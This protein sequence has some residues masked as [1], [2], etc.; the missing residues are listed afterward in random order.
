MKKVV[1]LVG[2]VLVMA[3]GI[4]MSVM[5]SSKEVEGTVISAE[6]YAVLEQECMQ[7]V[8]NILLEKG[9]KNAGITLTYVA[10]MEGN[11]EYT[12]SVHHKNLDIMDAEEYGIL[13]ARIKEAVRDILLG[14]ANF[15]KI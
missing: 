7:E 3:L 10:D 6:D 4:G 1:V 13:Q 12:V 15:K 14:N 8:K 5:A 2:M 9:C 11:R